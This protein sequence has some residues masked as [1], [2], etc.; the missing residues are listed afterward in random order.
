[1]AEAQRK[2]VGL[3]LSVASPVDLGRLIRELEAIDNALMQLGL[4]SGGEAPKLPKTT[5]LMDQTIEMNK[6]NLLQGEDRKSLMLFLVS[7]REK[8]PRL[9]M[10]FSADPSEKFISDL[11]LWLRKSVHPLVLL[12]IGLQPNIGAGCMVRTTNKY[13][14]FSLNK[15]LAKNRE[16]LMEKLRA[17]Q[18]AA[19]PQPQAV[20]VEPVAAPGGSA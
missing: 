15:E 11:I 9:H 12:T 13:F 17:D 3:P 2:F 1:M 18:V 4:R 20:P 6:L 7:I 8:A 14:D 16:M 5:I 10:S 19:M